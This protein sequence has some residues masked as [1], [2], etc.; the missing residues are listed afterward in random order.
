MS[1][2]ITGNFPNLYDLVTNRQIGYLDQDGNEKFFTESLGG[3]HKTPDDFGAIGDGLV[4]DSVAFFD[5]LNYCS[6]NGIKLVSDSSKTYRIATNILID[7]TGDRALSVDLQGAT[8]FLDNASI[9]LTAPTPFLTTTMTSEVTKNRSYLDLTSVTGLTSGDLLEIECPYK[10]GPDHADSLHYYVYRE[11]SGNK[12]YVES[13]TV[14]DIT[15]AQITASGGSG[16]LA[17]FTVN[18]YHLNEPV[19]WLNTNLIIT[20][21]AGIITG[22]LEINGCKVVWLDKIVTDGKC[23]AQIYLRRNA[24]DFLSRSAFNNFGYTNDIGTVAPLVSGSPNYYGYG[25][26]R[27]RNWMSF[28]SQC[29]GR[30]GWHTFDDAYGQMHS[31]YADCVAERVAGGFS[32]HNG[33]W[34]VNYDNCRVIGTLGFNV[35]RACNVTLTNCKALVETIAV[36]M[37]AINHRI[38]IDGC[39]FES[40]ST[41]SQVL[42][43]D[44]S[45]TSGVRDPHSANPSATSANYPVKWSLT[46]SKLYSKN[47]SNTWS[48]GVDNVNDDSELEISD[49]TFNN[50][51]NWSLNQ[52][53]LHAKSKVVNNK[54][55]G[56]LSSQFAIAPAAFP[57]NAGAK[58]LFD[59]NKLYVDGASSNGAMLYLVA[60]NTNVTIT[61]RRNHIDMPSLAGLVRLN[62]GGACNIDFCEGN[63][64]N[65]RLF[66]IN[67]GSATT[68][69]I[70]NLYDNI[71]SGDINNSTSGLTITNRYGNIDRLLQFDQAAI[72]FAAAAPTTGAHKLGERVY[73]SAPV[74]GGTEGWVCTA[75][76]SPGTWKT[77]GSISA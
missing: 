15:V 65:G 70:T 1:G 20:D 75:A 33:A 47:T 72:N 7:R 13:L 8:L 10:S 69:N 43:V 40:L 42:F 16:T 28:T 14:S 51:I 59:N 77:F 34:N 76:G 60:P 56:I 3:Q 32:T 23:R 48:F 24:Y 67:T 61:L 73:N 62:T 29:V 64:S 21:T 44:T 17:S 68:L 39:E 57:A 9:K 53:T 22:A 27:E 2:Y 6:Q 63:I 35:F 36:N 5:A 38:T 71:T 18:A 26:L 31:F 50:I 25:V 45:Y 12:C 49:V 54:F 19:S 41:S 46:K 30:H 37:S 52:G 55:I 11:R 4:D 66:F 74:A 58:W